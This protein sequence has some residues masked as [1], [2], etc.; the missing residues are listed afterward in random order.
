MSRRIESAEATSYPWWAII[1]PRRPRRITLPHG[2]EE[3]G[4]MVTG[5]FFS[6]AAAELE[7]KSARYNYG[8][9]A[10]VYCLSGYWSWDYRQLCEEEI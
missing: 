1:D 3:I 5:P 4:S 10:A 7:L 8:P 9:H 2:V 6:R